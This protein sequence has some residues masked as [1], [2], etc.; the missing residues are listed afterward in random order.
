MQ[1]IA[2]VLRILPEQED[3]LR[4]TADDFN[5]AFD[6]FVAREREVGLT[7]LGVWFQRDSDGPFL[8]FFL[9]GD[10]RQYFLNARTSAGVEEYIR[11][12]LR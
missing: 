6:E 4:A 8:I 2:F 3:D 1:R 11:H 9:E 12:K 7:A 5:A 10:L